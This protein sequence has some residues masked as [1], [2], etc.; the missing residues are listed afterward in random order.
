M[1]VEADLR[2]RGTCGAGDPGSRSSRRVSSTCAAALADH[3]AEEAD[4]RRRPRPITPPRDEEAATA[5]R[6]RGRCRPR[7]SA[8][9]RAALAA[10]P[11][12]LGQQRQADQPGHEADGHGQQVDGAG[13]VLE[14]RTA[15]PADH[16]HGRRRPAS[17]AHHARAASTPGV[18]EEQRSERPG[19]P[20]TRKG[21]SWWPR[22]WMARSATGP[23]SCADDRPR[24][25]RPPARPGSVSAHRDAVARWP[26]RR[27]PATRGR[28]H[29]PGRAAVGPSRR[30]FSL[31]HDHACG[32][33]RR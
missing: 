10:P 19:S 15:A 29:A 25:P 3:A 24:R 18:R 9:G 8:C 23:G 1:P 7:P 33:R 28:R 30:R 2:P 4:R 5:A 16:G 31:R 26:G 21:L 14:R 20:A 13:A 17:P 22:T 11:Q 12:R 27:E 32:R 6:R